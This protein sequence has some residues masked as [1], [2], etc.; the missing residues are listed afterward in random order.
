MSDL[1]T[2]LHALAQPLK[3]KVTQLTEKS[4]LYQHVSRKLK[5][6]RSRPI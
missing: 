6:Y 2:S 1:A 3:S 4:L 5:T